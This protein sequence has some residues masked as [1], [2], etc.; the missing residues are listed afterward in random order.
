MLTEPPTKAERDAAICRSYENG[1]AQADIA[2]A[3]K[4]SE[5]RI[6]QILDREGIDRRTSCIPPLVWQGEAMDR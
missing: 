5:T 3:F 2:R 1:Y 6:G 4:L